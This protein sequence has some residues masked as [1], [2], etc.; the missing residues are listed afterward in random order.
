ME[1]TFH[2]GA[3]SVVHIGATTRL[4]PELLPAG[5]TIAL[6]DRRIVELHPDLLEGIETILLDGGER[7]KTLATARRLYRELLH[8][9]ADRTT[10]L[11]GVGGGTVTDLAGFVAATYQRGIGC[12]FV[13][14]TLLAQVDAALGGKNGVN[15]DRYK[16]MVGTIRQ[17]AFVLC[18]PTLLRTLP[19]REFRAG[20]A[21]V[22]KS[23]VVGDAALFELLEKNSLEELRCTPEL[24]H[25][26][27]RRAAGVKVTIVN[28]D[29]HEAGLRRLLNLGHTL[30]HALEKLRCDRNHGEAVA[31]GLSAVTRIAC[32]QG[33]LSASDSARIIA[34]LEHYGF[35][36]SFGVSSVRLLRAAAKDKKRAGER[37][38]LVLPHSIGC[39][40]TESMTMEELRAWLERIT[41]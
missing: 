24:L 23:A 36:L 21:E 26:V 12:G 15:V 27:I 22:I 17:P 5:R 2:I 11:L 14:T 6:A 13:A 18:D 19:E 3:G 8:R 20:M 1:T 10:F 9:G 28:E 34:L 33:I 39:C 25:E 16:N 32:Q 38:H 30:G 41:A 37:L 7:A 40:E 31:A 35:D 4:L 29:E